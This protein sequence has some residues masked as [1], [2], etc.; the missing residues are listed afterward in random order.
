MGLVAIIALAWF[1]LISP[2]QLRIEALIQRKTQVNTEVMQARAKVADDR[3]LPAGDGRTRE[4][5]RRAA[6]TRLPSE[7]ETPAL[8]RALSPAA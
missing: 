7:R 1:F 6:R 2:I 4:A 3:A 8:Y 5:P